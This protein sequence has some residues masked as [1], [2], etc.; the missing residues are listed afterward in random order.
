[1]GE[2]EM[3][4]IAAWLVEALREHGSPPRLAELRREVEQFCCVFPVPGLDRPRVTP[5]WE[6]QTPRKVPMGSSSG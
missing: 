4:R 1:M 5:E 6:Q 3:R 2:P